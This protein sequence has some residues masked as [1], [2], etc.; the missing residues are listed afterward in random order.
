MPSLHIERVGFL[1]V[2]S[3]SAQRNT[4][5]VLPTLGHALDLW[6]LYQVFVI[7]QHPNH[8][9]RTKT[10]VSFT[11]TKTFLR[12]WVPYAKEPTMPMDWAHFRKGFYLVSPYGKEAL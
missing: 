12:L 6:P 2:A 1:D 9:H 3:I 10:A 8:F 11:D 4:C 5:I 7:R